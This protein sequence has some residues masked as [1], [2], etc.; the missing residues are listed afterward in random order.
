MAGPYR[1]AMKKGED[2]L[3]S[4]LEQAF[5][6]SDVTSVKMRAAVR[7]WFDLYY[8]VPRAGEDTAPRVAAL[9]VGKL[10]RTVFAEYETRLP[11]EAPDPLRR[12]LS[13]LNAAA[14]DT[15]IKA[16]VAST[17]YDMTRVNA[18]GYFDSEDSEEARYEKRRALNAQ[19]T[20]DYKS[21][22]YAR[23]G[24]VVDPLPEDA[25]FFVKDYYDYYKTSRGYHALSLNSN[26]GW[27]V[28]STL[29]FLNMPLLQ[30]SHEIRSAVLLIHGEKAHSCYFSR[31]A[32]EKLT[33]DNKELL[34]IPDAVHTDLYDRLDVIPFDKMEGFLRQYIG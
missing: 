20:A 18:K 32:F 4:Y 19:R 14:N 26:Q 3:Q 33:G 11:P 12:S 30:Y 8:G 24:G 10:C 9:I 6:K 2:D 28:T 23:A 25:P 1:V 29:P 31:D 34:L 21:G 27:N 13:A 15:R 17:M 22:T 7:E 16:T 5:G